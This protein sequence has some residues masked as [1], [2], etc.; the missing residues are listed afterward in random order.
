MIIV[1]HYG[2]TF[3]H[4][5]YISALDAR[6][7]LATVTLGKAYS[8]CM[9]VTGLQSPYQTVFWSISHIRATDTVPHCRQVRQ[10]KGNH[11]RNHET[12]HTFHKGYI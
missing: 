8:S 7:H 3:Y 2:T 1:L 9:P 4:V 10:A 12:G 11:S 6:D 5:R